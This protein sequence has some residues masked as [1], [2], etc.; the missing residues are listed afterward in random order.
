M[1]FKDKKISDL[2]LLV[3]RDLKHI[4][5][6]LNKLEKVKLNVGDQYIK[7]HNIKKIDYLK[8][9]FNLIN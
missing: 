9:G 1:L 6:N 4:H 8:A 3:K 7:N 2:A 5:I